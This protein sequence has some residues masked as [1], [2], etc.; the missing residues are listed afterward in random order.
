MFK[1][2][3]LEILR[4]LMIIIIKKNFEKNDS[5]IIIRNMAVSDKKCGVVGI[6]P[7]SECPIPPYQQRSFFR[8]EIICYKVVACQH[9]SLT[10]AY[11]C[12]SFNGNNVGKILIL[13]LNYFTYSN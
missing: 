1:K 6:S 10:S 2:K 3:N 4:A 9:F 11:P 7:G 13:Q 12:F 8:P 5:N